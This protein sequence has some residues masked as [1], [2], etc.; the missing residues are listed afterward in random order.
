MAIQ[1][2]YERA[3]GFVNYYLTTEQ[4]KR[5]KIDFTALVP[6][7]A[8]HQTLNA[9]FEEV[10]DDPVALKERLNSF[11]NNLE[12]EWNPNEQHVAEFGFISE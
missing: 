3:S 12:L 2:N 4:G 6:S 11:R 9:Y 5:V 1:D 8:A 7:K 10:K